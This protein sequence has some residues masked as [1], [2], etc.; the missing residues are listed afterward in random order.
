MY[1]T[2][3]GY[4]ITNIRGAVF[5]S[6]MTI[7]RIILQTCFHVNRE[8]TM[9]SAII[10]VYLFPLF[11]CYTCPAKTDSNGYQRLQSKLLCGYDPSERPVKKQSDVINVTISLDLK[12]FSVVS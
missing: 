12:H 10:F 9:L 2:I 11:A 7:N 5:A 6:Q 1:Y 3:D 4:V 8:F